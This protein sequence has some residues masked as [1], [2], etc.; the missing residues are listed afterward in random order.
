MAEKPAMTDAARARLLLVLLA[1]FWGM[2]WPAM[3]IALDE[4]TLWTLRCLGYCLGATALGSLLR[5]QGRS[6]KVPLGKAWFHV[7]VAATFNVVGFGLFATWAQLLASTSRVIIVNYSMPIWGSLLAYFILGERLNLRT[8]LGLLLCVA[9]LA[10]LVY[11]VALASAD[12]PIGL[13]L[14]LGCALSWAIGSIYMKWAKISGDL[15]AVTFW[16][17]VFGIPV[18]AAGY[19]VF[20]GMPSFEPL[21]TRTILAILFQGICG[22]GFAYFIWFNIIGKLNM[23][24]ASLGSL[25]NPVVG[26]V[27]SVLLLGERPTGPDIFG[28]V[29][30]FSA[31][32]CVL[33]P[34]RA[35]KPAPAS[36]TTTTTM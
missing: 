34:Q 36:T 18:F 29:L 12:E 19:L 33:L 1:V 10:V 32:C 24:A 30:I 14:A 25:A 22:T 27:G 13:M 4:V 31:A 5:F 6:F 21:Q 2:S 16:Q 35:P 9:G 17:I 28:F 11:P 8:A 26:I 23:A 7:A 15:L 20:V 3:R